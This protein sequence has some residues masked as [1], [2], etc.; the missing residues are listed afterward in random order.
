MFYAQ[1]L[2]PVCKKLIVGSSPKSCR[3]ANSDLGQR[4]KAHSEEHEKEKKG[5][6][7]NLSV[8]GTEQEQAETISRVTL[9]GEVK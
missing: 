5:K 8:P 4:L 9:R 6:Q 7:L 1:K 3:A 2:C